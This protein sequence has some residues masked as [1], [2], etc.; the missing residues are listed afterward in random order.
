VNP[1]LSAAFQISLAGL[2][3]VLAALLLVWLLMAVLVRLTADRAPANSPLA[4][5][6]EPARADLGQIAAAAVAVALARRAG[7]VQPADE[8]P[9]AG[10]AAPWPTLMRAQ[11]LRQRER[12][13]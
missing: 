11:W 8:R 1:N 3:L 12:H 6:A 10:V 9:A 4:S 2:S 7:G 13:R 5:A